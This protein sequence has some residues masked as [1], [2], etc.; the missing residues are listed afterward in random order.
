[1]TCPPLDELHVT[2]GE[3][4]DVVVRVSICDSCLLILT[5]VLTAD[6]QLIWRNSQKLL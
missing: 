3:W 1:M 5:E 6:L 4:R 2:F